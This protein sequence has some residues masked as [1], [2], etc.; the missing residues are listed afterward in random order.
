M[1]DRAGAVT[2]KGNPLTLVGQTEINVGDS[3]PDF[4]VSSTLV[5]DVRLADLKGKVV[6]LSVVPSLDT[7]VC[8]IQTARFNKEAKSLGKDVKVLTISVDLPT[9]QKRW[10]DASEVQNI[11]TASDYKYHEF[12]DKF[13]LQIKE[14]GVLARAIFVIDR[15]GKVT[16]KE[17]VK[18]VSAEPNYDAAIAAVK[19]HG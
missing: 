18:E 3:A 9:A 7:P 14:L 15:D 5:D 2:F 13:G 17:L 1:A 6:L 8:S 19:K 12:G 4:K 10:C 16:Y 11:T